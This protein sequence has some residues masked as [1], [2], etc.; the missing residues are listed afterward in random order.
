MNHNHQTHSYP[1]D[2]PL[3]RIF[4][5][6]ARTRRRCAEPPRAT[7]AQRRTAKRQHARRSR[8]FHRRLARQAEE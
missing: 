1:A 2:K 4:R 7:P 8:Q 3:P 5:I 6:D